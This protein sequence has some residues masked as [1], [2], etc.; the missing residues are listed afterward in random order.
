MSY[1]RHDLLT[2]LVRRLKI[3]SF[4]NFEVI[5]VD[6]SS[7]PWPDRESDYGIDVLYVHADVKG[8]VNARNKGVFYARGE[9]IAFIDDDCEPEP[10]WLERA[11]HHFSESN[12]VGIEG[13]I[14]TDRRYDPEY[15]TVTN[16]NFTGI[17]FMTAN[18][19]L[20][21]EVFNRIGGFDGAFDHPH[22]RE[23]TD[24]AWRAL[25]Y[26]EIPY[27]EDVVVYHPPHRRSAE[28]ESHSARVRFFEKDPLLLKKHP[29]RYRQLFLAEG[30]WQNT[31]G[32]W[33]NFIRGCKKYDA[34]ITEWCLRYFA[35][36][37]MRKVLAA[38][39]IQ[40]EE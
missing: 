20:R 1:E 28:R 15:R 12:I 3:Q 35:N 26:G 22:F 13:F 38:Q 34:T 36:N 4:E 21:R 30:H 23:D 14:R 32:F 19:F 18:L 16:D 25:E 17:G 31:E 39:G 5:I 27:F 7:E 29:H 37:A 2:A 10:S 40:E 8:A 6:Q 24:L 9:I 11:A 33:E